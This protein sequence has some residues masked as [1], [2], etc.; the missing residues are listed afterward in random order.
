MFREKNSLIQKFIFVLILLLMFAPN[1]QL[2]AQQQDANKPK[3]VFEMSL[4]ELMKVEIVSSATLTKTSPRLVPAAVTTITAEQIR[5]SGARSLF[6]LLDIYVPNLQWMRNHWE[7]DNMGLRGIINDRDD[8]YLLLVNGRIMNERTHYGALSERDLVMLGDIHHI[9]VVRGPGSAMYGPGA[10]S[11]VINIITYNAETFQ[12]TE[13]TSRLGAVEEFYA[14]EVKHGRKFD[15]NDGGFFVYT[16]IGKYNGA[17]KYDAPQIFGLDFPSG[18]SGYGWDPGWG[19][20][21]QPPYLP[22]D[23]TRAGKPMTGPSLNRDGES[24]RDQPPMKL[25]AEI[26]KGNWDLWGRYTSGGQQFIPDI[27]VLAPFP[28]GWGNVGWLKQPPLLMGGYGYQQATAYVGYKQELADNLNID[29]SFS[30]DMFDFER[31]MMNVRIQ[32]AF[33]EDTYSGKAILHWQPNDRH[34][35]AFGGE[36]LHQELGMNSPG[37][38]HL[39]EPADARFN[40]WPGLTKMPRW[41]TN[42]YSLLGE[43]QWKINDKWTTFIGG[44]L[45]DH[46]FTDLMFSPRAAII[47]MPT[48]KDTFKLMWSRSVRANYEEDMKFQADKGGGNS[49]PEKLD[50]LELR[51]ERKHNKNLDLAASMFLHYSLERIA[52]SYDTYGAAVVGTQKEWGVELEALYHTDRTRLGISHGYTKLIDFKLADPT[53]QNVAISAKPYGYG[54]DLANWSNHITKLTAQYKLNDKWTFDG[55]LRIYWGFPGM[56]DFDEY[57]KNPTSQANKNDYPVME[58]GWER[59]YRGNYYLNLGLQYKASKDLTI[60][61]NGYNLLGILNKDFN[62]RN[63]YASYGDYRSAAPAVGVSL[64]YKF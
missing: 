4:E 13:V 10:I 53:L 34:K 7:A 25:Y 14:G 31:T 33:R 28:Y 3:D 8:K 22:A 58:P 59:G 42:M 52:W 48:D 38:P 41:S 49:D 35:I 60:G 24:W 36:L 16:G 64:T 15:S 43:W 39:D 26:T 30:Y 11:M 6:E 40:G 2:L 63:Y 12:G 45:D 56:K 47:H 61:I 50:S 37:W 62:K 20:V 17:S 32:D 27:G 54:D 23:G 29:Y 21:A 51:Y 44:R 55:S 46:T 57:R 1:V 9:D 19:A 5:G 18:P